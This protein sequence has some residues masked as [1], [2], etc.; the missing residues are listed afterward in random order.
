MGL[1][2]LTS[3]S[4]ARARVKAAEARAQVADGVNPITHRKA[5][6][7]TFGAFTDT[8]LDSIE[9]EWRNPKHRAQW[10]MTLTTY[11]A[12]LRPLAV[13]AVTTDDVL[14]VLQP[15]WT[16]KPETASR[17]RGR[18]ER[19]LDAAK[20]K[21]LRTGENPAC[22]RGHLDHLLPKRQKLSRGHH[23]ALPVP[24]VPA[25]MAQLRARPAMAARS[26]EFTVLTAARTG[27]TLGAR[28]G[29]IDLEAA[30]WTVP[31]TRMKAG[32][33]HRVPLSALAVALL[34]ALEPL[35]GEGPYVFPGQRRG[36]PLSNMAM[37]MMLRRMGSEV[38]VH[39]FRSTFRD[40]AG[41]ETDH[42]REVAE[43]AL[44]HT[45][46]D[47]TERAYRR[48]DA[49]AKRRRLMDDW[50][51]YCGLSVQVPAT[52]DDGSVHQSDEQE[53]PGSL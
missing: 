30:V 23:T 33:E 29:E 1:G 44:A 47:A 4:L 15:I 43:A 51:A 11:A 12:P 32:R 18:I 13:D 7:L 38:T 26:L 9:A 52:E 36:K 34:R 22:W 10:R 17:V 21:G 39:G 3:V 49:L 28:W 27:E 45:V 16:E 6:G 25:F 19:V 46:G 31:A 35:R 50:A 48:G 20:A 8:L 37:D 42:P 5:E 40:W 41:E 53:R 2:G 24:A 14:A